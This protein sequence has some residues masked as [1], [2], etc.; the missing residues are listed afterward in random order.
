M[1]LRLMGEEYAGIQGVDS[2][3][4]LREITVSSSDPGVKIDQQGTG[5]IL[6]LRDNGSIV[7][8]VKDGGGVEL[9]QS[10]AVG[11]TPASSGLIRLPRDGNAIKARNQADTADLIIAGVNSGNG[12]ELG[13][14]VPEV[15]SM[16]TFRLKAPAYWDIGSSI[17]SGRYELGRNS[18]ATNRMQY[19]VPTGAVHE[20]SVNGVQ[21]FRVGANAINF[22]ALAGDDAKIFIT[23]PTGRG[24]ALYIRGPVSSPTGNTAEMHLREGSGDGSAGNKEYVLRYDGGAGHLELESADIDGAGNPGNIA[25]VPDGGQD[26]QFLGAVEVDGALNHDGINVG[27][28]GVAP[29]AQASKISDPTGGATIDSEARTAINA[30]IDTLEGIGIA[31]AV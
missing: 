4:W 25:V 12:L 21:T 17:N 22:D 11:T 6:E 31:A 26:I 27:L 30:I 16:S 20:F 9:T 5:P 1:A 29:V 18:D 19:N 15:I 7:A 24:A 28:Y 10:L 14:G 2:L 8:S 3:G 23:G 13:S